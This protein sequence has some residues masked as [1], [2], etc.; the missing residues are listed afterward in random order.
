MVLDW[1]TSPRVAKYLKTDVV[2]GVEDQ[3]EWIISCRE[4]ASFYHWLIVYLGKPIGYI[5]ISN[6]NA[7]SK[8]TSWGFYIGDAEYTG[9]GGLVPPYFYHF[10]FSELGIERIDAEMLYFNTKVIK[11][12]HLHGYVFAPEKDRILMREGKGVLLIAMSLE[13]YNFEH[14]KFARFSAKF[15]TKKWKAKRSESGAKVILKEVTGTEEQI[16]SLYH[17]LQQRAHSISHVKMP[18]FEKHQEFVKDHPYRKWW[19]VEKDGENIGSV[20]LSEHNGVG[21]NLLTED[22]DMFCHVVHQVKKENETLPAIP[23]VRPEFFFINISPQ[24]NSL[25]TALVNMGAKHIQNS[26]RI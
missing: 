15:P 23:S 11:L 5:S 2:H 4:C 9:L 22:P 7:F 25:R 18:S 1:R 14:G 10:C 16:L 19:L 3:E 21:V 17:L 26:Y 20:Y 6:F 24:N 8:T 13:K 12:H